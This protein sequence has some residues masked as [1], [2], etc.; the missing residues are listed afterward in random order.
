MSLPS[1][2]HL[3][4]RTRAREQQLEANAIMQISF[5]YNSSA[6]DAVRLARSRKRLHRQPE[7]LVKDDTNAIYSEPP[8]PGTR[9]T[10]SN[11]Q[12][13]MECWMHDIAAG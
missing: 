13:S 10:K 5:L 11:Q 9:I 7:N 6:L 3:A 1:V 4:V 2:N 8:D 12:L